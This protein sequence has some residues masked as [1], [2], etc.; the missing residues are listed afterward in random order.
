MARH[1][2]VSNPSLDPSFRVFKGDKV[3]FVEGFNYS[4]SFLQLGYYLT[5]LYWSLKTRFTPGFVNLG[6][7][8]DRGGWHEIYQ[9]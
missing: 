8:Y 3:T 9:L 1:S 5:L 6:Y 7:S 2:G 4:Y